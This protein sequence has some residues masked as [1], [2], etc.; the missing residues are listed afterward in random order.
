MTY[1]LTSSSTVLH[2]L[3]TERKILNPKSSNPEDFGGS[4]NSH[5]ELGSISGTPVRIEDF[6]TLLSWNSRIA[7]WGF[8]QSSRSR[9]QNNWGLRISPGFFGFFFCMF[10]VLDVSD[11]N[12]NLSHNTQHSTHNTQHTQYCRTE[13]RTE[14][15]CL[16]NGMGASR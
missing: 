7:R 12:L 1:L 15:F 14:S 10:R 16:W 8:P 4:K 5:P 9:V 11:L 13:R 2:P 3:H 6:L